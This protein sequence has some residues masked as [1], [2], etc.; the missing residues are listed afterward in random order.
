MNLFM[1][2][3]H[4]PHHLECRERVTNLLTSWPVLGLALFALISI[5]AIQF[6]ATLAFPPHVFWNDVVVY[7]ELLISPRTVQLV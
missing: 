3:S 5:K 4:I 1:Y 2:R 7:Y 6:F